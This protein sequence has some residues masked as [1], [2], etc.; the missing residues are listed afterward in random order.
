MRCL[1]L[2]LV[3]KRSHNHRPNDLVVLKVLLSASQKAAQV[4]E[5]LV[6]AVFGAKL[7]ILSL[8]NN[9]GAEDQILAFYEILVFLCLML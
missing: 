7:L 3:E 4:R 5:K 2:V 6:E 8:G 1:V 9:L